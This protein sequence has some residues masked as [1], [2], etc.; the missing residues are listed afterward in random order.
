[1]AAVIAPR[2][3]AAGFFASSG[4]LSPAAPI[5]LVT[6]SGGSIGGPIRRII[7]TRE[8]GVL[9]PVNSTL[10]AG[11]FLAFVAFSDGSS[12]FR[13]RT[14]GISV[15]RSLGAAGGAGLRAGVA[16]ADG[17]MAG[18]E[19][20]MVGEVFGRYALGLPGVHAVVI[21]QLV[22]SRDGIFRTYRIGLTLQR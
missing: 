14:L 3:A 18:N 9:T 1:M 22:G 5:E 17:S 15:D 6:A 12:D 2:P 16:T 11:F 8:F 4:Y 13:M 21:M 19:V 20:M 10:A 7:L